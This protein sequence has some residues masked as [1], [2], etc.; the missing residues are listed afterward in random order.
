MIYR[1][2]LTV[3]PK[4]GELSSAMRNRCVEM[5]VPFNTEDENFVIQKFSTGENCDFANLSQAKMCK[6]YSEILG[7]IF[8]DANLAKECSK[9]LLNVGVCHNNK[10][11]FLPAVGIENLANFPKQV[12]IKFQLEV[13]QKLFRDKRNKILTFF[14]FAEDDFNL[15]IQ[16]L[17]KKSAED[18]EILSKFQN[19]GPNQTMMELCK[20]NSDEGFAISVEISEILDEFEGKVENILNSISMEHKKLE[21]SQIWT[22]LQ[23]LI[24]IRSKFEVEDFN[25][26]IS[27]VSGLNK[28]H[29]ILGLKAE[30]F[31]FCKNIELMP[32]FD[33]E[34]EWKFYKQKM[35]KFAQNDPYHKNFQMNQSRNL[36]NCKEF[37]TDAII[38]M[39]NSSQILTG[40]KIHMSNLH[41]PHI[42]DYAETSYKF[43]LRPIIDFETHEIITQNLWPKILNPEESPNSNSR[44]SNLLRN[45]ILDEKCQNLAS[46]HD[47]ST[48]LARLKVILKENKGIVENYAQNNHLRSVDLSSKALELILGNFPSNGIPD[49]ISQFVDQIKMLDATQ[50]KNASQVKMLT[51]FIFFTLASSIKHDSR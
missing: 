23:V 6:T 24:E 35:S 18:E 37:L 51:G 21:E 39:K 34:N 36:E 44:I 1:V 3:N 47:F 7:S 45:S 49:E 29:E 8:N 33:D 20:K 27:T 15:R 2:F 40:V 46:W 19:F 25:H 12:V 48:D 32:E 30:N 41:P 10:L 42:K 38:H 9:S 13:V 26:E 5:F 4:F 14:K 43:C 31:E 22:I 28:I 11:E 17:N 16:I 50:V